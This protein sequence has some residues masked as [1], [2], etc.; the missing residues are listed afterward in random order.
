MTD[1]ANYRINVFGRVQGV[2]FRAWTRDEARAL[3]LSG[4]VRNEHDGSVT[5]VLSGPEDDVNAM[6]EK[7]KSGPSAARVDATEIVAEPGPPDAPGFD[8]RR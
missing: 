8:I 4:W 2:G 3:G 1:A 6:I 5:C 7:L